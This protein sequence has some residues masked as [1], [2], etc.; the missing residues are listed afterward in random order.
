VILL[1]FHSY[2][3]RGNI[4]CPESAGQD[5]RGVVNERVIR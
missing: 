4:G 3:D 2:L 5:R 1:S